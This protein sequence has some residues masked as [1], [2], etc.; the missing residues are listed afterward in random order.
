MWAK[1]G[2]FILLVTLITWA[3]RGRAETP[4]PSPSPSPSVPH[5]PAA[6]ASPEPELQR[7][8][9]PTPTATSTPTPPPL[10]AG[11]ACRGT[12]GPA[13]RLAF[14]RDGDLWIRELPEGAP[15][16]LTAG[17]GMRMPRW[18]PSGRWLAALAQESEI[19][20][21]DA[22][23][24]LLQRLPGTDFRW[25]PKEDRLAVRTADGAL[26]GLSPGG[27]P[28]TLLP[29]GTG[30]S[31]IAWSPDGRWIA[32]SGLRV[33]EGEKDLYT[34]Q[35]GARYAFLGR[36]RAEG[37]PPQELLHAGRPSAYG[38][39][40]A[41]WTPDGQA[42]LYWVDPMFSGSILADGVPLRLLPARGGPSR[43]L[44]VEPMLAYEDFLAPSPTGG[45]RIA[46]VV[47]GYRGAWTNKRLH[48]LSARTGE[49]QAL[50]P[51]LLAVSSP[52]WSAD[53]TRIAFVAMPDRGDLMGGEDA[54]QG[55]LQR[56]L[57]V[58]DVADEPQWRQLTD[59]PAYRDEYPRW[60]GEWILFVRLD[61]WDRASL[62]AIP[63]AGGIPCGVVEA[64]DPRGDWFGYYGHL[65]WGNFLDVWSPPASGR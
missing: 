43:S 33:L 16:R 42:L 10:P 23:G 9:A 64:L 11:W 7:H 34:G 36:V 17:G 58:V 4:P 2:F 65:D 62:W 60:A 21:F 41:G 13:G 19:Q 55:L 47:G 3:C 6:V 61:R 26:M 59:D 53:G 29:A 20:I 45:D 48:L 5:T 31:R 35:P 38:L 28:R 57:F 49:G 50:S 52:A 46:V 54:R 56:R 37:G 18:S 40:L 27:T 22:Q 1:R 25:S 30:V 44:T 32:Y 14:V 63:A 24:R 39:L 51:P 12:E 8:R 15:L